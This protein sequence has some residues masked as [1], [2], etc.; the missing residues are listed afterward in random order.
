MD[1]ESLINFVNTYCREGEFDNFVK[2]Y[3]EYRGFGLICEYRPWILIDCFFLWSRTVDT[4][5]L[6]HFM[7]ELRLTQVMLAA[8]VV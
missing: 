4:E 1:R 8:S 3:C 2:M 6:I 7:E 5:S